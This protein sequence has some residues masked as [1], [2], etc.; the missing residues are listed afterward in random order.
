LIWLTVR[1]QVLLV[2]L[3]TSPGRTTSILITTEGSQTATAGLAAHIGCLVSLFIT[4]ITWAF[5]DKTAILIR[6]ETAGRQGGRFYRDFGDV[7]E[8]SDINLPEPFILADLLHTQ[9]ECVAGL[10]SYVKRS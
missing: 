4:E 2:A 9:H 10:Q 5:R 6:G 8:R 3:V 1:N 7:K